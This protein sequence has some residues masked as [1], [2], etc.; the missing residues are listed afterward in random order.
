MSATSHGF[1]KEIEKSPAPVAASFEMSP[2]QCR[3]RAV[4][5]TKVFNPEG[6]IIDTAQEK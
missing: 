5:S 4:C 1:Q 2:G 3:D 6:S